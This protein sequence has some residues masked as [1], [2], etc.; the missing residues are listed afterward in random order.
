MPEGSR[1]VGNSIEE[2]LVALAEGVREAQVALNS[3]PLLDPSGRPLA[4][5]Q[6]PYLDFTIVVEVQTETSSG[7][8]RPI[9]LFRPV[10]ASTQSDTSV[11]STV[12][13][14]LIAAP[15]G[16]GLPVPRLRLTTTGNI[17]GAATISI[18]VSNSAGEVLAGQKVELN[19]DDI[20]SAKLTSARNGPAW[21]R[22]A[23]TRLAEALLVT[24]DKGVASTKLLIDPAQRTTDVAVV[25]A[26]IGPFN[27]RGAVPLGAI[28]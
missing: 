3:V 17:A 18:E 23:N 9:A 20:A 19:I 12:A 7:G 24:D 25:F 11:K 6:L 13:G 10:A 21:T 28:G 4:T 16:D 8:G 5:Y 26:N 1:F 15:P 14:R 22:L 2:L 27:A